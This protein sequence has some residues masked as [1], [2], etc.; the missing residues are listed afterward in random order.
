MPLLLRSTQPLSPPA[1][2]LGSRRRG[3]SHSARAACRCLV[4]TPGHRLRTPTQPRQLGC[5]LPNR[6]SERFR[7]PAS[8]QQGP[9]RGDVLETGWRRLDQVGELQLHAGW[10]RLP[11]DHRRA[12]HA[13]CYRTPSRPV[14]RS[15]RGG[16][17]HRAHIAPRRAQ[18]PRSATVVRGFERR[19]HFCDSPGLRRTSIRRVRDGINRARRARVGLQRNQTERPRFNPRLKLW[20]LRVQSDLTLSPVAKFFE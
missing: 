18:G 3:S 6:G 8:P 12:G 4:S 20:I 17:T 1:I 10:L 7:R 15:D 9:M 13:A 19:E 2:L 11:R 14:F 16:R 5:A